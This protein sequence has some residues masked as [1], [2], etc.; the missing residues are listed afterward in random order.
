M[1]HVWLIGMMGTGKTSSGI[2]LSELLGM[3][4]LDADELIA[5]AAGASISD[6]FAAEGESGFR[7]RE[8][9]A[10]ADIAAGP[11]A[12]VAAG[13]GAALDPENEAAMR[14]SGRI[15]LLEASEE[16][17]HARLRGDDSRPLLADS[18]LRDRIGELLAGRS[19]RYREV[20][21]VVIDTSDRTPRS[22]AEEIAGR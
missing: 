13:G 2:I 7:A 9:E 12:V 6:I 20:A 11:A 4:F 22:V 3:P 1:G 14:A 19:D 17:L 5:E 15:V 18:A 8:R 21:D 16:A 10:I